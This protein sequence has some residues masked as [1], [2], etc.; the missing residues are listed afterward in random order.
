MI[1]KDLEEKYKN[2]LPALKQI[3]KTLLLMNDKD[4][5]EITR[6]KNPKP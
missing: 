4:Y 6:I 2:I 5:K 3:D 1:K